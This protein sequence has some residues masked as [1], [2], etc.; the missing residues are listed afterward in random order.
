[1]PTRKEIQWSQLKVG[2]LVL[3]AVAV[4]IFLI[5]LMSGST[6]GPFARKIVIR[7][8]FDNAT[9]LKNGAPV[10]LEGVT[11]GNVIKIKVVPAR[12]PKPVEVTM[13]IGHEE[14]RFLHTDSTTVIAQ[15]GVLGDSFV[16]ITSVNATGPPP[17]NNTEL[18]SVVAPSIQ[19]VVRGSQDALKQTT[20]LM[21]KVD[22]FVDTLNSKKGTAG[23][24]VNDPALYNKLTQVTTNL[25]K[26][27]NEISNGKGTLGKLINDDAIYERAN[28]TVDRLNHIIDSLDKGEGTAGKLLRDDSLY[29]NLNSAVANT[30]ELVSNINAGKGAAGKLAKDPEFAR[31]LDS[32]VTSLDE[33]LKGVN[34]GKGT[35]GQLVVNKT[36]YDHT[37]QTME[38]AQLLVK[39]IRENPKKYLVI[40]LK[41]F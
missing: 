9:G 30:N 4:L 23:M 27:T 28:S 1:V 37:D 18:R 15:A 36:L 41:L 2:A 16:D 33:L 13:R 5:F 19:E 14:A 22:T 34:E 6:G 25:A 39:A 21:G 32:T 20:I 3:V 12:S 17:E 26:V 11:I 40:H 8:Y 31:K 24:L 35:L 10:T 7:S 38:Q 29:K